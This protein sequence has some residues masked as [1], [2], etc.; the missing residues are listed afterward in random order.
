MITT[1]AL[2]TLARTDDADAQFRLGYRLAL[3]RNRPKR[4]S[5]AVRHWSFAA[6]QGHA[7]ALFY[8]GTC[9]DFGQGVSKNARRA[10]TLYLSAARRGH[11]IA[12]Y[13]LALGYRDGQ[14]V[15]RNPK[16]AIA[17]FRKA[18]A[19]GD[20]GAQRDLGVCFHKGAGV[21][22][23]DK[24]AVRSVL[25]GPRCLR[26]SS[27]GE[28]GLERVS[29]RGGLTNGLTGTGPDAGTSLPR[30]PRRRSVPMRWAQRTIESAFE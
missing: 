23:D 18:S 21:R 4:W 28:V 22:R 29:P 12:Q 25:A 20:A 9:Y 7:R 27:S 16:L 3:G 15:R 14:G 24:L 8:L 17:W 26:R 1:A 13:N 30:R 5:Q 10:M 11:V 2:R 19:Q 6:T